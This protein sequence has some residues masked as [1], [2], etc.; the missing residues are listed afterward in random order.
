MD[1]AFLQKEFELATQ[2]ADRAET[3]NVRNSD[4]LRES[5][6]KRDELLMQLNEARHSSKGEYSQKLSKE[7][8]RLREDSAREMQ[9]IRSNNSQVWERENGMLREQKADLLKQHEAARGDLQALRRA[10]E[11]LVVRHAKMGG[12]QEAGVMEIRNELK[13]KDFEVA[14]LAAR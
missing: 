7:I 11:E 2:R 10:H 1:K 8:E 5:M 12:E 6:V 4:L 14:K 9:E 13:M 3:D